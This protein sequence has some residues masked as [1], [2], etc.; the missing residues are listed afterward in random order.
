M[1]DNMH[2]LERTLGENLPLNK[3]RVNFL[4]RFVVA[5]IQVKTTNLSE[6]S[7]VFSGRAKT[8][9]N[10]KRIQR[11]LH[12]FELSYGLVARFIV[13]L[14][15]IE[16][17]FVLTLDRTVWKFGDQWLNFLVLGIAYKG[18]SV[19]LLWMVLEKKGNSNTL[20]RIA[21]LEEYL[22]LFGKSSIL[23]LAADR[24]FIGKK[25]FKWLIKEKIDFRIRVKK[26]TQVLGRRGK[27]AVWKLFRSQRTADVL[28][29]PSSRK[30]WGLDLYFSGV[31][32]VGG[33]YV[34][35]VSAKFTKDALEDYKRRWE[36]ETMF[37]CLK[38]RGFLLEETHVKEKERLKKLMALI[39]IG[40][41]WAIVVGDWLVQEKPLKVKSHGRLAKSLF[42]C[43]LDHLRRILCNLSKPSQQ[44]QF[45][46][47]ITL[48]SCT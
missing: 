17:P 3:A 7:V 27:M 16:A 44:I 47:V 31:K 6:I 34:V 28:S 40:F 4:A 23:F 45:N 33:E 21:L 12:F 48:L 10:Y 41:C 24:E 35:V 5:L 22:A 15:P 38:S 1:A 30:C 19:P 36:I 26:D 18:V 46:R 29:I 9:S 25:W 8:E 2:F 39:A 11:F 32:L 13:A 14:L 42:R 43:G 20:E 37:G